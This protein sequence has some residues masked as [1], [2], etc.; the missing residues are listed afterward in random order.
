[1][2]LD[3]FIGGIFDYEENYGPVAIPETDPIDIE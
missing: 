3:T 2:D 1:M